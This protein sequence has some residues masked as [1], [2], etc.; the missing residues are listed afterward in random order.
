MDDLPVGIDIYPGGIAEECPDSF[1]IEFRVAG[2]QF[3]GDLIRSTGLLEKCGVVAVDGALQNA[4]AAHLSAGIHR[5]SESA[6][7]TRK[8]YRR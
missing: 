1:D 2:H 8:R 4:R 6:E 7:G 5:P 3:V